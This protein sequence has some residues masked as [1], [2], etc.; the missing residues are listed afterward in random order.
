MS[1]PRHGE[2][3]FTLLELL[4]A[5]TVML[6]VLAGTAEIMTSAMNSSAATRDVIDMNSHLRA[7]MDLLQRDL[8]QAGQG[9]P[10]GR[11]IGIPHDAGA[12]PIQ[13]PGPPAV[14][15]CPG[16]VP[17]PNDASIPAVS[18]GAGLG[19]ELNGECTDVITILAVDNMFGPV[20]LAAMAADGRRPPFTIRPTSRTIPTPPATTC[21]PATC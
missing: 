5:V 17:F 12:A 1:A 4:I 6:V 11:R 20:P 9:L 13:R 8:L 14:G 10:V 16:V 7:G 15:S 19:P 18:V 2:S 3:G 21:A